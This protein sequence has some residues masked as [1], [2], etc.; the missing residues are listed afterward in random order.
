MKHLVSF[1][2]LIVFALDVVGAVATFDAISH[3]LAKTAVDFGVSTGG[4]T[5]VASVVTLVGIGVALF[6]YK[7]VFLIV[8]KFTFFVFSFARGNTTLLVLMTAAFN[9][10]SAAASVFLT[11][12]IVSD[13]WF[14]SRSFMI[15]PEAVDWLVVFMLLASV[16]FWSPV[17]L[18]T[19]IPEKGVTIVGRNQREREHPLTSSEHLQRDGR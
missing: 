9:A 13:W 10:V 16:A 14:A 11:S 2:V 17:P 8:G 3:A 12:F 15:L 19:L 7:L 5:A 4:L 6:F 1:L 18:R